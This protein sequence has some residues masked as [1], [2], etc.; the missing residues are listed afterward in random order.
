MKQTITIS[1]F[2]KIPANAVYQFKPG[3]FNEK[4]FK[5]MY[6][7]LLNH[8]YLQIPD[9][10]SA[11]IYT[12]WQSSAHRALVKQSFLRLKVALLSTEDGKPL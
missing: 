11:F 12:L 6:L 4:G 5:I 3:L 8:I 2:L 9:N 10:Q 1:H 7:T